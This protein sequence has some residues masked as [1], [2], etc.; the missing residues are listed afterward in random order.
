MT[1]LADS[2]QYLQLLN[3]FP[4]RPIKSHE[5]FEAVQAVIDQLL[6]ADELSEAQRDYLNLLASLV[7]EYESGQNLM[8]DLFGVQLLKVLIEEMGLKQKDLLP[9]FKTE[10]IVSAVLRGKR[11][12]TVEHI[13]KL[14]KFFHVS[15]AVFFPLSPHG[16]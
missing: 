2:D 10:S 16:D 15:P 4:P 11:K 8:P 9:I 6:D 12:F 7:H 3:Q 1:L 5:D 14:A 13:E